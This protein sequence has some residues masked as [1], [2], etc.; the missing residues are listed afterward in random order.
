MVAPSFEGKWKKNAGVALII[1]AQLANSFGF[2]LYKKVFRKYRTDKIEVED[3]AQKIQT[4]IRI[5]SKCSG[6]NLLPLFDLWGFPITDET[7]AELQSLPTFLPDDF[8][9]DLAP[10]QVANILTK[11]PNTTRSAKKIEDEWRGEMDNFGNL[12]PDDLKFL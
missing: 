7:K 1:Y 10:T 11:Y 8:V 2:A 3:D 6:Y 5:T 9:T 4:W 12:L